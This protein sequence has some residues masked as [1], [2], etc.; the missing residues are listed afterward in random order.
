MGIPNSLLGQK[1]QSREQW[2]SP[3]SFGHW[4]ASGYFKKNTVSD[5]AGC[6]H[7]PWRT[8]L[9]AD[10]AQP[11]LCMYMTN[12]TIALLHCVN[13]SYKQI[14]YHSD[15]RGPG[16]V[17]FPLHVGGE[18]H[19]SLCPDAAAVA[20]FGGVHDISSGDVHPTFPYPLGWCWKKFCNFL[21]DFE[22]KCFSV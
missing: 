5:L 9:L 21:I 17:P 11:S 10:G 12:V 19:L 8:A 22:F 16:S 13:L 4:I 6:W 2:A 15:V 14:W 1:T 18:D 7:Q 20:E 3:T